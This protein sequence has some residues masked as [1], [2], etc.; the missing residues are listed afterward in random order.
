[1]IV[2]RL[3]HV[4][5]RLRK[6][7]E[8]GKLRQRNTRRKGNCAYE[9]GVRVSLLLSFVFSMSFL[10]IFPFLL[11]LFSFSLFYFCFP[12]RAP[13]PVDST[14]WCVVRLEF[15]LLRLPC[16]VIIISLP[17]VAIPV[18]ARNL[19][20]LSFYPFFR[21]LFL[22]FFRFFSLIFPFFK[23]KKKKILSLIM[24]SVLGVLCCV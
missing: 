13:K 4:V 3:L 5:C 9:H 15:Y 2:N 10:F 1:M 8:G 22:F 14:V 24:F 16:A 21:F 6:G 23:K 20:P 19:L 7:Q 17:V 18:H 11:Y 12:R